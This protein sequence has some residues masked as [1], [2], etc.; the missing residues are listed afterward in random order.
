M[1]NTNMV[2]IISL[3]HLVW[4]LEVT[5]APMIACI[6]LFIIFLPI[7]LKIAPEMW[8]QPKSHPFLWHWPRGPRSRWFLRPLFQGRRI[9]GFEGARAPPERGSA[10]S[11]S[12]KHPL[13]MKEKLM[14]HRFKPISIKVME[15]LTFI[16]DLY[17]CKT[18]VIHHSLWNER[19][20]SGKAPPRVSTILHPCAFLWFFLRLRTDFAKNTRCGI[21]Q[22]TIRF[23]D[24][25]LGV[26]G[27]GECHTKCVLRPHVF[28]FS[29][30]SHRF[31]SKSHSR[32]RFL[33]RRLGNE[34]C[35]QISASPNRPKRAKSRDKTAGS[36]F[37]RVY[38]LI[39]FSQT[40][41]CFF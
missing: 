33:Q 29:S 36:L 11:H 17:L 2:S 39:E 5:K 23:R 4:P 1:L 20:T 10:P 21:T 38:T 8:H 6:W 24:I 37:T 19:P 18:A 16:L 12:Q 9:R 41:R 40:K 7:S 22:V 32:P 15:V 34:S 30:F 28:D 25:D 27:Q 3:R 13:K 35:D 26:K 14:K 31:R